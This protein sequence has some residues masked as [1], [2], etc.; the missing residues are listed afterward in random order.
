MLAEAT[1]RARKFACRY[2]KLY[3]SAVSCLEEDLASFTV[4]LRI[5][6]EHWKLIRHSN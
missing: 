4:H 3:A 6:R 1:A 2:R 5:P